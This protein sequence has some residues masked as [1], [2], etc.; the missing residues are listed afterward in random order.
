MV[1]RLEIPIEYVE[2]L[3]ETPELLVTVDCQYGERNVTKFPGR[4][5]AV[6]DHHVADP[7]RLPAL[8]KKTINNYG[9]NYLL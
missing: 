4:T 7:A 1:N 2:E 8:L 9:I 6:I 3:T 5:V